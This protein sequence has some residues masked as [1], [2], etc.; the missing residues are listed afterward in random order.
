M[1]T[2]KQF[3]ESKAT[4]KGERDVGSKAY[5]DYVIDLTPGA[6]TNKDAKKSDKET[7]K[8]NA[9]KIHRAT[10]LDDATDP[11]IEQANDQYKREREEL[12]KQHIKNVA[13]IRSNKIGENL[14]PDPVPADVYDYKAKK[15]AIAAPGSGSIAKA[16]KA[17]SSDL[18]KSIEQQMVDAR[19]EDWVELD[20]SDV[21]IEYEKEIKIMKNDIEEED[22]TYS[23][24]ISSDVPAGNASGAR[25]SSK[26]MAKKT[27]KYKQVTPGQVRDYEKLT[28]TRMFQAYEESEVDEDAPANQ[29][30]GVANWDPLLGGRKAKIFTRKRRKIDARSKDYR[31]AIKRTQARRD[32]VATR[33][34]EHKLNMFGVQSNP[35][36]EET[37]M[38]N[39]KYLITKEGSIEAAVVKSVG[40]ETF[41]NPNDA[42]PTLT[43]PNKYLDS[44]TGTLERAVTEVVTE[45]DVSGQMRFD[46]KRLT[47]PQFR[48]KYSMTKQAAMTP[49]GGITHKKGKAVL[50]PHKEEVKEIEDEGIK[51]DCASHVRHEE[52]GAGKCIPGHHTIV[53]TKDGEGYVTHYD[54]MFDSTIIK[55]VPIKELE[56]LEN[57]PHTHGKKGKGKN[58]EVAET[59]APGHDQKSSIGTPLKKPRSWNPKTHKL[60]QVKGKGSVVVR[61]DDPMHKRSSES[62][63]VEFD[64][65]KDSRRTV[66][67]IRAYDK[68]KDA[69]RDADWDTEH[70]KKGKGDKEKK[71]AKK[72]RG[73]IDKD[74][75]D[76]KHK[77]G[78][79]GMHGEETYSSDLIAATLDE[80]SK[81][82]LGSYVKKASH[83][84]VDSAMAL[85]RSSDKPSGQT[86]KDVE[87]HAGKVVRRQGGI[88]K[89]VNKLSKED[90][91]IDEA[92][93]LSA[94]DQATMAH[95]RG[96]TAKSQAILKNRAKAKE[97]SAYQKNVDYDTARQAAKTKKE[98]VEIDEDKLSYKERQNLPKGAF[99]LP[100]KG[101]GPEGKQGG[102]YPIPD[103]SHGRNALARVSQ[104]GSEAEKA[105][106]RRAVHKKFPD[107]KVSEGVMRDLLTVE[108][109]EIHSPKDRSALDKA[110]DTYKEKGGKTTVLK[111]GQ[112][113]G[114]SKSRKAVVKAR[115]EDVELGEARS[116]DSAMSIIS[117]IVKNKQAGEI[118]HGD[119]KK[120]K[121]D[122][123]SASA[124]QQVYNALNKKNQEKME[125]VISKNRQGLAKMADFSMSM[126][127]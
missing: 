112:P 117:S 100:G 39:K 115:K 81:K 85:Q 31:E 51:H 110:I 101:S 105:T 60:V 69:S 127:K 13:N 124:I 67:A 45:T 40:T 14:V 66:D 98:E 22:S 12:R 63:S 121:V 7:K 95:A 96:D 90:T 33:E 48:T 78:H 6:V 72:E 73:E 91:E 34:A 74:D 32:A 57:W 24:R 5:T 27:R 82:T 123:Y 38:K 35:F 87:K 23:E 113:K 29:T 108:L 52:Y 118:I 10:R 92:E 50:S 11:E 71:Y 83:S 55:D 116:V 1:K 68:S 97:K 53:E 49:G 106:V 122:L 62:E 9:L 61:K 17:K 64:E 37:E 20:P 26:E 70:G 120:S 18:N 30:S 46:I 125:K 44:K 25:G 36:K 89:A 65:K 54:V 126:M 2:I 41:V 16:R 28:A 8:T 59:H 104:H 99:A 75:P 94:V 19:K 80:L 21:L 114:M 56:I 43:L 15:G 77:K 103:E 102:S 4:E 86:V 119:R 79:T 107:I 3:S 47:G 84:A 88:T 76:W 58:E 111:S 42:R 93:K 109:D